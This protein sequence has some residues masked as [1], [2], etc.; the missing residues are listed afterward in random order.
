MYK[1]YKVLVLSILSIILLVG[2][3]ACGRRSTSP[4]GVTPPKIGSSPTLATISFKGQNYVDTGKFIS[5]VGNK[6]GTENGNTFFQV[7]KQDPNKELAIKADENKFSVVMNFNIWKN[8]KYG[9]NFLDSN[10]ALKKALE[11]K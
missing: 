7:P 8:T 9:K 3:G 4:T 5:K 11:S 1:F 2:L 6:L 10:P